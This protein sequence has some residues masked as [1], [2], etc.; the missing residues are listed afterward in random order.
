MLRKRLLSAL[1][2][3]SATACASTQGG[4]NVISGVLASVS[5]PEAKEVGDICAALARIKWS[6]DDPDHI[7]ESLARSLDLV[8]EMEREHSCE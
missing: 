6:E 7:S 5:A 4:G 1:L 3:L 8:L 2:M